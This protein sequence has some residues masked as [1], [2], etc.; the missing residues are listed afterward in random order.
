MAVYMGSNS[1]D[2][3]FDGAGDDILRGWQEGNPIGDFGPVWDADLLVADLGQDTWLGG[4]GNDTLYG[5]A[6]N[7]NLHGGA[8]NDLIQGRGGDDLFF[9]GANEGADSIDGG[10]GLDFLVFDRSGSALAL[11]F[12]LA[13]PG[14]AE[15]L[16][17]GRWQM[18]DGRW[19]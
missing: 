7:D 19:R 18:A 5:G 16:A 13:E 15:S 17:D 2:T 11:N 9:V 10:S 3:L 14:I 8:G 1:P 4:A 6:E 12:T